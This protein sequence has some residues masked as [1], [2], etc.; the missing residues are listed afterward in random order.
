MTFLKLICR[1]SYLD[2]QVCNVDRMEIFQ[3][4]EYLSHKLFDRPL[5]QDLVFVQQHLELSSRC[6][7][8]DIKIRP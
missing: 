5:L 2:I 8:N 4:V 6:P 7:A 3:A 1:L